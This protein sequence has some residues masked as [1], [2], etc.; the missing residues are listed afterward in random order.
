MGV[1][2]PKSCHHEDY[3]KKYP[4]GYELEYVPDWKTH[5]FLSA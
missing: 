5:Q 3:R 4:G 1:T 2:N